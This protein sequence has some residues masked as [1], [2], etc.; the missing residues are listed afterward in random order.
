[1]TRVRRALSG[2]GVSAFEE[3]KVA[4]E[5]EKEQVSG[6]GSKNAVAFPRATIY[7]LTLLDVYNI[8]GG[9]IIDADILK[10]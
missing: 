7:F 2:G 5:R 1:M 6:R 10:G 3:I 8:R 9:Y 4:I